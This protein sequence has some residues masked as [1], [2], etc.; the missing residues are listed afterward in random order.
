MKKNSKVL[1]IKSMILIISILVLSLGYVRI[2]V[3]QIKIGY[4][5]SENNK[6]EKKLIQNRQELRAQLMELKSPIRLEKL[7]LNL[8]FKFPTPDDIIFVDKTTIVGKSK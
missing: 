1:S 2:K 6:V 7:A 4:K 5:I 8:G 3:E